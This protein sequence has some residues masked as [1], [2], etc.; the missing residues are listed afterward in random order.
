MTPEDL[1]FELKQER[2]ILER[3]QKTF[4]WK[5]EDVA[6]HL[7]TIFECEMRIADYERQVED[8]TTQRTLF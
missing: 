7:T 1:A 5:L 6:A 2:E 3:R 4:E 8:A